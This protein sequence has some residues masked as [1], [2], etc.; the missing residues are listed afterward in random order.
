MISMWLS[1]S[2]SGTSART[3]GCC[4]ALG[5][6]RTSASTSCTRA[7]TSSRVMSVLPVQG[8]GRL[9]EQGPAGGGVPGE[10]H[11]ARSGHRGAAVPGQPGA[12]RLVARAR[13]VP[14]RGGADARLLP[15]AA[16]PGGH[17]DVLDPAPEGP[18]ADAQLLDEE[19]AVR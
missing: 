1:E 14:D 6:L 17:Q 19:A 8:D 3:S 13:R 7:W 11:R 12:R 5:S 16:A 2:H 10:L 4:G 15:Q 9:R 18:A